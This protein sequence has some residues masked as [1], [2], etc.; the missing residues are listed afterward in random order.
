MPLPPQCRNGEDF[1]IGSQCAIH[2]PGSATSKRVTAE[3]V[4][5]PVCAL[6]GN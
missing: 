2:N 1:E 3:M 5:S 4:R 6:C